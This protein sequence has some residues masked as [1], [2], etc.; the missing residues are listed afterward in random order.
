[1][2]W[3]GEMAEVK[4]DTPHAGSLAERLDGDGG[5]AEDYLTPSSQ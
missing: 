3:G 4:P 1:M 5:E 2:G